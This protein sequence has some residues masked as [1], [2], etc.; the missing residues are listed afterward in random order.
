MIFQCI[1]QVGK[2][3][4]C[5]S[6]ADVACE[7]WEL[8]ISWEEK[9]V[10]RVSCGRQVAGMIGERRAIF[11]QFIGH[12]LIVIAHIKEIPR[13][14]VK[15]MH[16]MG[17]HSLFLALKT[18][19]SPTPTPTLTPT[20]EHSMMEAEAEAE[21]EAGADAEAGAGCAC[22]LVG[23]NRRYNPAFHCRCAH[24]VSD[25]G[26]LPLPLNSSLINFQRC[27]ARCPDP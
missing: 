18:L 12:A 16:E 26:L 22:V 9:G 5:L 4:T 2:W 20:A 3:I 19:L 21:A 14:R 15:M 10:Y 7:W 13:A 24:R 1:N 17:L 8:C 27:C 6:E 11:V 23:G 25:H